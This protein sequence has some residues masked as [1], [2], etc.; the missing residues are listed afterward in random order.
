MPFYD[1][2][3]DSRC[4]SRVLHTS[5]RTTPERY[6]RLYLHARAIVRRAR[7]R[8]VQTARVPAPEVAAAV[9]R[10]PTWTVS[11]ATCLPPSTYMYGRTT[12]VRRGHTGL[13]AAGRR[14]F[15][16][17][18]IIIV[19]VRDVT[20]RRGVTYLSRRVFRESAAAAVLFSRVYFRVH[21]LGWHVYY[22]RVCR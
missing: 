20:R 15:I 3:R 1:L 9:P 4:Q 8:A 6:T 7:G 14:R 22:R 11:P 19:A 5:P 16:A 10:A 2:G 17:A 12:A 18:I 13:G 21:A